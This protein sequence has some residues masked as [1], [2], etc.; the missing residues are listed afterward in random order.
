MKNLVLY[1]K[2]EKSKHRLIKK[3]LG[4]ENGNWLELFYGSSGSGKTWSAISQAS[5]LDKDF[6]V[7][8]QV[9]FSF[10][11]MMNLINS[12]WFKAKKIKQIVCDEFQTDISN[13]SWQSL[14]NK[15]MNYVITTFRHQNIAIYFCSPYKDFLDSGTMKMFH[16]FTELISIDLRRGL[17]KTRPLLVQYNSDM[18]KF[19]RHHIYV[20]KNKRT[21]PL[22]TD[23]VRK[24]PK[25]MIEIYERMKTDFTNKLNED[26]EAQLEKLS[27]TKSN[28]LE[29]RP[30]LTKKQR[31]CMVAL[32]NVDGSAKFKQAT[33]KV[34]CSISTFYDHIRAGKKK[35]YL[36][37]EFVKK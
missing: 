18:K 6:D 8:K 25:E 1:K 4:Q 35:G 21:V 5:S 12:E 32:A 30:E 14:T 13:R 27:P 7:E 26:I 37:E 33:E 28:E 11:D 29:A 20:I 9:V 24:P 2:G 23:L 31:E 10:R 17:A 16:C 34:G 15:L 19:Y 36:L 3:V 22:K